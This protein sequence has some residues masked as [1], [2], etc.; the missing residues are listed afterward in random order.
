M[1]NQ[2]PRKLIEELEAAGH[3]VIYQQTPQQC[4]MCGEVRELRPYGL[5]GAV[6]CFECGDSSSEM[7]AIVEQMASKYLE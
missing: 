3:T 2:P 1:T 4:D 7:R 6:I 5:N